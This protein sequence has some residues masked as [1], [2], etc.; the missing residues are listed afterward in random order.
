MAFAIDLSERQSART[1]EQAIRHQAATILET[2]LWP[3]ADPIVCHLE[4]ALGPEHKALTGAAGLVLVCEPG[5]D[6]TGEDATPSAEDP[7]R[8]ADRYRQLVGTYCDLIIRLGEHLYLAATDVLK[9]EKPSAVHPE[10]RI[11]VSRPETLQVAQRRVYRRIQ[12][13]SS[14]KVR[15]SWT[16]DDEQPGEGIGWLCNVSAGG[17]SCRVDAQLVDRLFIG[18]PLRVEF[19]LSPTDPETFALDA[20]ICNKTPAGSEGKM[21][22]GMQFV[23]GTGHEASELAAESL[24]RRLLERHIVAGRASNE[25][26]R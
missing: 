2:R 15:M 23:T 9:V 6:A 18:E 12:L 16:R 25:G 24:R 5:G 22:I 8:V 20:V 11:H 14:S 10:V 1:L 4:R 26:G 21:L 19:R 3:A 7:D 13:G 17:I